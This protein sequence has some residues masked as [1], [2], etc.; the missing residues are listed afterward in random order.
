MQQWN[1]HL[2]R[3]V[4]T[5]ILLEAGYVGTKGTKQSI[6]MSGNTASPGPGNPDPRRPFPELGAPIDTRNA[7]SSTYHG[8]QLKAEKR[9]SQGLSFLGSYTYSKNINIGGD[10]YGRPSSPQDPSCFRCDRALSAFS[11]KNIFALN[12]VYELPFGR[13][14]KYGKSIN[15]VGDQIL[16]GWQFNGIVTASS[17]QPV[18][19]SIPRDIA[20]IGGAATGQR[21]N[22]NG[23]PNIDNATADRWFDTS[24]FSEPAPYTFGSAGRNLIIGPGNQTWTLGLFKNFKIKEQH[25]IQFRSEFF[26]AFNNV[27]LG[28]PDT[29]FDSPNFGRISNSAYARQIQF[30]LKYYF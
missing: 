7:A 11:R 23:N 19:V 16:G 17:G 13:G 28:N 6:F 8:L 15:A 20:N 26:N 2:Q 1:L 12:F 22:L 18:N 5:G 24:V 10:G 29:N 25:R 30:G 27:N 21:P 4:G 9:F 3:E 14:R